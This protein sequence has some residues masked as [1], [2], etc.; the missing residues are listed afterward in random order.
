MLSMSDLLKIIASDE[1]AR[2]DLPESFIY[3]Q[4]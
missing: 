3:P 2:A 1:K 4:L